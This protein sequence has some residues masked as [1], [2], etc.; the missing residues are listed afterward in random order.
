MGYAL[1]L[2]NGYWQTKNEENSNGAGDE[3]KRIK[4]YT[5]ITA[6]A[7]FIQP[8][9]ALALQGGKN[10]VITL[11]YA[12]KRAIE[13]YFQVET[14]EIGVMIMG[15]I[16]T[17]NILIFEASE[18][19]LGVLSQIVDNPA[20]FKAVMQNAF[21]FLFVKNGI[22]I[23]EK[24]LVPASYDDLLSYYNQIHHQSINRNYIRESL[25]I[26]KD[27]E[28]EMLTSR[29][30]T[31]YDEQ[32]QSLQAARDPDSSTEDEL[33]KFLYKEGLRLP[34][35]AQ[36]IIPGMFVRP[37]FK[38]KPN[39]LLFCDGSPHDNPQVKR[40]D[41]EKRKALIADGRY[42]VLSWYYKEPL[43]DFVARRPDIFKKIRS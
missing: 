43:K 38:Y 8:V 23:P 9:K 40:E 39:I 21:D 35:E 25:R 34:D 10:G 37:D 18:G 15:E 41:S 32:Y 13:N 7:L 20:T 29:V 28:V 3:I 26:L 27:S 24:D 5:T 4:L 33:L 31:S 2:K 16:D 11:M 12:L 14:N 19:S 36:P 6:N 22:E 1:N 30:F 17:P 42:Q